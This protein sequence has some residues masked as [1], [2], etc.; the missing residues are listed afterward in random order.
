[1]LS[2]IVDI[3][4]RI[5]DIFFSNFDYSFRLTR[6]SPQLSLSLFSLTE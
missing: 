3:F 2:R 5:V 1:M 4:S 6:S